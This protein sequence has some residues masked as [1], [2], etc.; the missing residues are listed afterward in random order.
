MTGKPSNPLPTFFL[1]RADYDLE[2]LRLLLGD[3][4]GR[5]LLEVI[6]I[7]PR[8]FRSFAESDYWH[9][10]GIFKGKPLIRSADSGCGIELSSDAPYLLD[11]R[12]HARAQEPEDT[13]ACLI[14]T[15]D[16]CME[17]IC[18]EEP[19]IRYL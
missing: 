1:L 15:A 19:A 4:Q 6:F 12:Q 18:F 7:S 10:L 3:G 5:A 14:R 9:Y 17:V 11:Y 8:T 13:F 16:H 2:S